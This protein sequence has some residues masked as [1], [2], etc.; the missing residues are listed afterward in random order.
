M[1]DQQRD[2]SRFAVEPHTN[3]GAVEDQAHDRLLGQRAG[4]PGIP[5]ALHLAPC[6]AHRVLAD[7]SAKQ[8]RQR[9]THPPCIGAGEIR[10]RDQRVG[11]KRAPLIGPQ[12]LALPFRRFALGSGQPGARHRNLDRPERACQRPRPAAVAVARNTGSS[13]IAGHPA[14]SITRPC[15]HSVEL[16]AD[17]LF[18]ELTRSSP[19]LGLDRINPIVEKINS[20]SRSQAAKNQ[21]SWYCSSWRGLQSDASTPD[22]S[23]L[24][25][26][27]TTPPSI[28]TN[29]ATAPPLAC[30]LDLTKRL[31]SLT[32]ALHDASHGT[33]PS[34]FFD[35]EVSAKGGAP[36]HI[37]DSVLRGQVVLML[38]ILKH[39]EMKVDEAS[40]WLA[41]ELRKSGVRHK[42]STRLRAGQIIEPRQIARWDAEYG[43]K[44]IAART[45]HTKY[46]KRTSW[47]GMDGRATASRQNSGFIF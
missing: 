6:P 40:K 46:W 9:A 21:A 13:F 14:S 3:H 4:I 36:T 22:D 28:P 18:D 10:A 8:G 34:L 24:N 41:S 26:P 31:A 20:H 12:R 16:A 7:R 44:W 2:G 19:H 32:R 1:N 30:D 37:T 15:Q 43:A 35:R 42:K 11:G 25:T 47:P 38:R 5:V 39:G 23:R 29:S 27:E 33:R 45:G 17:Q